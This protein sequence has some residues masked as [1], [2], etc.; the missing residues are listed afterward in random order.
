MF[1]SC[2][3]LATE[4]KVQA[5]KSLEMNISEMHFSTITWDSTVVSG[6]LP[7]NAETSNVNLNEIMSTSAQSKVS[8][9]SDYTVSKE[10]YID[11]LMQ[12]EEFK[13]YSRNELDKT[14]MPYSEMSS[15]LVNDNSILYE[16][17]ESYNTLDKDDDIINMKFSHKTS[18]STRATSNEDT[19]SSNAIVP[20]VVITGAECDW[21]W[22]QNEIAANI[23]TIHNY[24]TTTANGVV[25]VLSL[26]ENKGWMTT[27]SNLGSGEEIDVSV[28]FYVDTNDF[29]T[30]GAKSIRL[31]AYVESDSL[32]YLTSA[33]TVSSKMV[34][35]YNNDDGYLFDPDNGESLQLDDLNHQ[36]LYGVANQAAIAGDNTS[37]PDL[38]AV[39][40]M[41]YVH[42]NM[43]YTSET[44]SANFT[45]ADIWIMDNGYQGLCD[46]Y[47][48]LSGSYLR[49]LGVPTRRVA[50]II[51]LDENNT[52]GH[53]FNEFWVGNNWIHFDA[54]GN[55]FSNPLYY[56]GTLGLNIIGINAAHDANDSLSAND[57]P[58]GDNILDGVAD[59]IFTVKDGM[60]D[61]YIV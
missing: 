59:M 17:G 28:P 6:L 56:N 61:R 3:G 8:P 49:A 37:T 31:L 19:V 9:E 55:R 44:L 34:E 33:P 5:S 14:F 45:A 20:N 58:D 38:T 51:R 26:D 15:V 46:E 60:V 2:I 25:V 13:D 23:I 41:T 57:G 18:L 16:K 30:V 54:Q 36:N 50:I 42:D 7:S 22:V 24:G 48:V 11:K 39:A 4:N 10:R 12:M 47:A 52:I 27:Y 21:S 29:P 40:V 53:Q 35:I 43:E 32:Y 1:F